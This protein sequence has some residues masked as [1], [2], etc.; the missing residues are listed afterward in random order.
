M[1]E[2]GSKNVTQMNQ[3]VREETS[4]EQGQQRLCR[5]DPPRNLSN[6]WGAVAQKI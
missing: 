5:E 3:K 4:T 2:S 6:E 1:G